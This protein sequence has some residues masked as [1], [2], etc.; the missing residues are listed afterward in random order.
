MQIVLDG[1]FLVVG[2]ESVVARLQAQEQD[3]SHL[4]DWQHWDVLHLQPK[5]GKL[6]P[7]EINYQK[8]SRLNPLTP[9]YRE[10][11]IN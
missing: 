3:E 11:I 8:I 1:H 9:V 10:C 2:D 6:S 4:Q 7:L 5:E